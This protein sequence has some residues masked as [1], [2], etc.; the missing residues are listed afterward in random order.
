MI[1]FSRAHGLMPRC[2]YFDSQLIELM[3]RVHRG[4][5]KREIRDVASRFLPADLAYRPSVGQTIPLAMWFRG[6]LAGWLAG[7]LDAN[8]IEDAGLF[9]PSEVRALYER[10]VAGVSNHGWTLWLL[11]VLTAWQGIVRREAGRELRSRTAAA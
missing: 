2:P 7:R 10:H 8:L 1:S 6:P 3:Y 5:E 9:R 4:Y 11:A